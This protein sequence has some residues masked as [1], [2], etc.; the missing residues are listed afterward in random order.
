MRNHPRAG[1]M[2]TH[3]VYPF[4]VFDKLRS[5][6]A[7]LSLSGCQHLHLLLLTIGVPGSRCCFQVR[8]Q[9]ELQLT[10]RNLVNP[11]HFCQGLNSLTLGR[12]ESH[13]SVEGCG[14]SGNVWQTVRRPMSQESLNRCCPIADAK[15]PSMNIHSIS[16][17]ICRFV[18]QH[19]QYYNRLACNSHHHA[20]KRSTE[21]KNVLLRP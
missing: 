2:R 1:V 9:Q 3:V 6:T 7:D 8:S 13:G 10:E 14:E 17:H 11:H 5:Q 16:L 19:D 21:E 18:Q 15:K 12:G 4:H 20:G